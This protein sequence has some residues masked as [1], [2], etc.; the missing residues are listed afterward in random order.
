MPQQALFPFVQVGSLKAIQ[1]LAAEKGPEALEPYNMGYMLSGDTE[2][3]MDPY[4]PFEVRPFV[5]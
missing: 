3:A 4:Y 2:K 1:K 5:L